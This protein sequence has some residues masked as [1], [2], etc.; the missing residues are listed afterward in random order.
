MFGSNGRKRLCHV[1]HIKKAEPVATA[2]GPKRPWLISNVRQNSMPE[3]LLAVVVIVGAI[4]A[5]VVTVKR[6]KASPRSLSGVRFL[7]S[8][9]V[10]LLSLFL[11]V[12]L[13]FVNPINWST[14]WLSWPLI[15][16]NGGIVA[17]V[18]ATLWVSLRAIWR[19]PNE[20]A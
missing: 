8:A 19:H 9:F 6:S 10:C 2:N 20:N 3:V 11:G 15:A 5:V 18:T 13:F 4:C 12:V 14:S 1:F 16:S 7:V 17:I